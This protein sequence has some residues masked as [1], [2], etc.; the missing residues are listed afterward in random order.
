MCPSN[1]EDI[2]KRSASR[3]TTE[4][5]LGAFSRLMAT[6]SINE[7][8]TYIA[9]PPFADGGLELV[10]L[11]L[12]KFPQFAG[13]DMIVFCKQFC[14]KISRLL[15]SVMEKLMA[16]GIEFLTSTTI[17]DSMQDLSTS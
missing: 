10:F 14:L 12:R 6:G 2:L 5:A 8:R 9:F 16:F 15:A 3:L 1:I 7:S 13:L 4:S 11:P 17:Y